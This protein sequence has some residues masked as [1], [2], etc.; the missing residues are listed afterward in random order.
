[1]APGIIWYFSSQLGAG[2]LFVA[3]KDGSL[4]PCIE[5]LGPQHDNC[6]KQVSTSFVVFCVGLLLPGWY[7]NLLQDPLRPPTPQPPPLTK[8]TGKLTVRKGREMRIPQVINDFSWFHLWGQTG[9]DR[10]LWSE[11]SNLIHVNSFK[12]FSDLLTYTALPLTSLTSTKILF[13]WS[14]NDPYH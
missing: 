8:P 14:P 9:E 13:H 7:V 6:Q 3:K 1:M 4:C 10:L 11:T 2:F 12:D 5:L